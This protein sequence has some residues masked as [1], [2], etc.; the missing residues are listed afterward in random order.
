MK[1]IKAENPN[2]LNPKGTITLAPKNPK[3]TLRKNPET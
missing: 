1:K 3:S 2:K